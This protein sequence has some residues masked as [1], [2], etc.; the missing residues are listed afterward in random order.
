M[1]YA[2]SSGSR[3]IWRA[4]VGSVRGARLRLYLVV[5]TAIPEEPHYSVPAGGDLPAKD[6]D[7]AVGALEGLNLTSYRTIPVGAFTHVAVSLNQAAGDKYLLKFY[8]NGAL[9]STWSLAAPIPVDAAP[10]GDGHAITVNIGT[11]LYDDYFAGSITELR[12]WGA[13]RD[14]AA[15]A[16][17]MLRRC[18]GSE[19]GLLACWPLTDRPNQQLLDVAIRH[20][21]AGQALPGRQA[22][23]GGDSN[24]ARPTWIGSDLA[25]DQPPAPLAPIA[26]RFNGRD[27][28]LGGHGLRG[29]DTAE[30][31]IEAWVEI[32]SDGPHC[33]ICKGHAGAT[34]S[35]TE[36]RLEIDQERH[37][38]LSFPEQQ[39][40]YTSSGAI[41]LKTRTHV[42][43]VLA[44][45][46]ARF[47]LGGT[48]DP[49]QDVPPIAGQ[50]SDLYIGQDFAGVMLRGQL[51]E[52]RI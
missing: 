49:A 45:G 32:E 48:A 37:L 47:Y 34:D 21:G 51:Q 23:L 46:Q 11:N 8:I 1:S 22:T 35:R 2:C 18:A 50:G 13:I 40:S 7:G 15:I 6:S 26:W 41:E 3:W 4:I 44:G 16:Q 19:P 38:A 39:L 29:L 52:V 42:A 20:D 33:L 30:L 43:V 31:T 24:S 5:F 36:Y 9:D 17:A 10:P 28:Y 12:L 25:L 14:Q 27:Q